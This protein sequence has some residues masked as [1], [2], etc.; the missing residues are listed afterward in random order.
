M[1][2]S[3]HDTIV[4]FIAGK[5]QKLG[6]TIK[7]MEGNHSSV[8]IVK[9]ELPPAISTHR[10][11]V[12]GITTTGIIAIGEAKMPS[13]FYTKRTK[14]QMFDFV[15]LI[16]TDTRNLLILGTV[17]GC[18]DELRQLLSS[19]GI[20]IDHQI[21]IMEIPFQFLPVNAASR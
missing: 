10:P 4:G 1:K 19:L 11:D 18:K 20:Q 15:N 9:P 14:T 2:F 17:E 13:D 3:N 6:F 16:R 8:L 7:Y 5:M 12:F 21:D